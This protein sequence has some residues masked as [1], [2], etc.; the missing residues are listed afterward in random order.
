[1]TS[2]WSKIALRKKDIRDGRCPTRGMDPRAHVAHDSATLGGSR[3][4]DAFCPT[5]RFE[6]SEILYCRFKTT[7]G[8][9]LCLNK[10]HSVT[11]KGHTHAGHTGHPDHTDEPHNQTMDSPSR[12]SS[13]HAQPRHDPCA[14]PAAN[15]EEAAPCEP[16]PAPSRSQSACPRASAQ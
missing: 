16:D 1:M 10:T 2:E 15:S 12:P 7:G 8:S 4:R 9:R 14:N 11:H 6:R 13:R 3:L 5:R